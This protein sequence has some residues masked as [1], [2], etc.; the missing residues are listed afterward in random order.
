ML[1]I[2]KNAVQ[3]RQ[4]LTLS[5]EHALALL[6]VIEQAQVGE[7]AGA[8]LAE[9]ARQEAGKARELANVLALRMAEIRLVAAAAAEHGMQPDTLDQIL[10]LAAPRTA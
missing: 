2:L 1:S 8:V 5:A 9:R 10:R 7:R 6:E 3:Q 4:A